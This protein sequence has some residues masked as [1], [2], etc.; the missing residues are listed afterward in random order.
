MLYCLTASY[1]NSFLLKQTI[2]KLRNIQ[3]N[4]VPVEDVITHG[5]GLTF[6]VYPEAISLM[7]VPPLFSFLFF[8][9]LCLLAMSSIVGMMEPTVAAVLDEFPSLRQGSRRSLVYIGSCFVAFLGGL[10]M[11]FPSGIFMFNIINDHTASTVLYMSFFEL[12][13]VSYIYGIK[14]FLRN[15]EDMKIWMPTGLKY[16]WT[17]CW[18]VVTPAIVLVITVV[19]F[20]DRHLDS[21]DDYT[22]PDGAQALAYM[23]ELSP[24]LLVILVAIPIIVTRVRR[25]EAASLFSSEAWVPRDDNTLDTGLVNKTFEDTQI[26]T[27]DVVGG[28]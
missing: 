18:L 2:S 4:G 10:S 26:G 23:L 20:T 22:Y 14:N 27:E 16:F 11:C 9:M 28:S 7:P 25:G 15:I 13:V 8:F 6:Q 21:L 24:V 19:G 3:N 17:L 1:L 5:V 12:V